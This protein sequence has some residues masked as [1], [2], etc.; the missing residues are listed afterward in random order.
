VEHAFKKWYITNA[1]DDT[2]DILW[3]NCVSD[4]LDLKSDLEESVDS[5]CETGRTSE[6]DSE[7]IHLFNLTYQLCA[8]NTTKF[9]LTLSVPILIYIWFSLKTKLTI[10]G[11]SE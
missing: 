9:F 10:G 7:Q 8:F 4:C 2:E 6:E 11:V 1:L 3:V 5:E